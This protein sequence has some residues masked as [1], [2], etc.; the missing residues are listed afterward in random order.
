VVFRRARVSDGTNYLKTLGRNASKKTVVGEE[1]ALL[2][3]SSDV[4]LISVGTQ[5]SVQYGYYIP[6]G[7]KV[8]TH[9]VGCAVIPSILASTTF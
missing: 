5:R 6:F 1:S 4:T 8:R 2:H 7:Q 9:S 3:C